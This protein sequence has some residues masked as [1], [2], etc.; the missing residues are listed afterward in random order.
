MNQ[1]NAKKSI[2]Q[3]AMDYGKYIGAILIVKFILTAITMYH[4][5]VSFFAL[6]AGIAIPII[7]YIIIKKFRD[8][9]NYSKFTQIWAFGLYL[10]L[11]GALLSGA[12]EYIYYRFINPDYILLLYKNLANAI[13][14]LANNNIDSLKDITDVIKETPPPTSIEFVLQGVWT[15]IFMGS[16]YSAILAIFMRK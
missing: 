13:E 6:I 14:E 1:Q 11:F 5:M 4:P 2:V 16:I 8:Q 15:S 7:A 10:F 9:T 12:V 3:W